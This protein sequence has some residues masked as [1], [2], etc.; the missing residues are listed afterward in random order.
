MEEIERPVGVQGTPV[1]VL[2]TTDMSGATSQVFDPLADE[3]R[4]T[5]NGIQRF[6]MALATSRETSNAPLVWLRIGRRPRRLAIRREHAGSCAPVLYDGPT[7]FGVSSEP[8][9]RPYET[10]RCSD[11]PVLAF[12]CPVYVNTPTV[13][14][15]G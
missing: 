14:R 10:K 5:L 12:P 4:E 7:L 8:K 15:W 13:G 6:A 11:H 3:R 9:P 1:D 2:P